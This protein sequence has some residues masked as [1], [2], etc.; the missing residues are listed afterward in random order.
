MT[1]KLSAWRKPGERPPCVGVW[2]TDY[3]NKR[4]RVFQYWNGNVWGL[5]GR[6][7]YDAMLYSGVVSC[8]NQST[9]RFRGLA[10]KPE[11]MTDNTILP[12]GSAFFTASLPLGA[13]HWL[14]E[15]R[16]GWDN[17]RDEYAECPLPILTRELQERVTAAIRYAIRGATNCGKES[18][19][20]PDAL[21]LNAVYALCGP[22]PLEER[23]IHLRS[24]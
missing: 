9:I 11:L 2:E 16:S 13:D 4:R 19:F 14:Y 5:K 6:D 21:V 12:D 22:V 8:C 20:D 1:R 7:P 15:P 24:E 18:D 3:G 17:E 23:A 10:D